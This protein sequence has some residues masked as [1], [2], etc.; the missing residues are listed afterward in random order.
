MSEGPRVPKKL[1]PLPEPK[2]AIRAA[3]SR[4]TCIP[5]SQIDHREVQNILTGPEHQFRISLG[6]EGAKR[7][8]QTAYF[9]EENLRGLLKMAPYSFHPRNIPQLEGRHTGVVLKG[10]RSDIALITNHVDRMVFRTRDLAALKH[11]VEF[12]QLATRDADRKR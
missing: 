11:F 4:I 5:I 1:P 12:V 8:A 3:L 6:K 7:T 9:S 10:Q 2:E